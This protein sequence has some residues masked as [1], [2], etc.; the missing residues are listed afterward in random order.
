M[1]VLRLARQDHRIYCTGRGTTNNRER[2][3]AAARQNFGDCRQHADLKGSTRS[4]AW[5]Y[6]GSL[7][8]IRMNFHEFGVL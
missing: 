6:Q 7:Y 1:K 2:V 8:V 3:P 5:H 4:T